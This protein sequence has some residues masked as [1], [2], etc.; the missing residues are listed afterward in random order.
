MKAWVAAATLRANA[1]QLRQKA[2]LE[3]VRY[4]IVPCLL[5]GGWNKA[6]NMTSK[7]KYMA[8]SGLPWIKEALCE[9]VATPTIFL[10]E[11]I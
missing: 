7:A 11:A 10:M 8:G 4:K 2:A 3:R 5:N 9:G 6:L 1:W